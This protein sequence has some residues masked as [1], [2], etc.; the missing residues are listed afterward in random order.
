M[1]SIIKI[2]FTNFKSDFLRMGNNILTVMIQ[3]R[4]FPLTPDV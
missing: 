1:S 2:V 3:G 4:L